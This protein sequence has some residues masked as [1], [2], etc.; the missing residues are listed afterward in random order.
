MH[1]STFQFSKAIVFLL[2]L[3]V[4]YET[5]ARRNLI[6][7][8]KYIFKTVRQGSNGCYIQRLGFPD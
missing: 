8:K 5:T 3:A 6:S 7:L 2:L 1:A 4:F